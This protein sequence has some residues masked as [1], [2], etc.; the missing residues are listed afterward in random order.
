MYLIGEH[1][2]LEM[3][4]G[5]DIERSEAITQL[6]H[7]V[8]AEQKNMMPFSYYTLYYFIKPLDILKPYKL[9]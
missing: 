6:L 7:L 8:E 2:D 4:S 9:L 5:E 1:Q 3:S